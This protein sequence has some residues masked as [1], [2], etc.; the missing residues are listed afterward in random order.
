MNLIKTQVCDDAL[1]MHSTT[2]LKST[3][4][5]AGL[6]VSW[7]FPPK[8]SDKNTETNLKEHDSSIKV[9][10]IMGPETPFSQK[11]LILLIY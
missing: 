9:A 7:H 2:T 5:V 6:T 1:P 4:A 10:E 3:A 8:H 11:R